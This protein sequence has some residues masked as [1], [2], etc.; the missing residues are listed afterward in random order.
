MAKP[1][2]NLFSPQ[3]LKAELKIQ[4]MTDVTFVT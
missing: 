4:L 3:V 2:M 1:E